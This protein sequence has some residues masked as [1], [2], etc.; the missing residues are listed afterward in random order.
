MSARI[1][2]TLLVS[3]V[4]K[5]TGFDCPEDL[6]GVP[7]NEAVSGG[8]EKPEQEKSVTIT[9]NGTSSVTP[10]EGK[11]LKKVNITV[12]VPG[13]GSTAIAYAWIYEYKG[14][15]ICLYTAFG[16]AP[17]N[18]DNWKELHRTEDG[19]S[20]EFLTVTDWLAAWGP[21]FV[22]A[23]VSDT[24]FTISIDGETVTFTRDPAK[25]FTMWS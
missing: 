22:Y 11:T 4:L 9:E 3:E 2:D 23:K 17:A 13:G 8:D 15:R 19:A 10:D 24:E 16:T 1:P 25:D 14:K 6:E 21:D 5:P 18:T 20:I 12:N 7:F